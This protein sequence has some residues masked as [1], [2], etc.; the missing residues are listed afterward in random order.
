MARINLPPGCMG[1][2]DG[3]NKRFAER[4]NGGTH[5]NLD[6]TDPRDQVILQKMKNQDY[7]SAGLVD[8]GPEK[9]FIARRSRSR[10]RWCKACNFLGHSWMQRCSKC[11]GET[12]PEGDMD[13]SHTFEDAFPELRPMIGRHS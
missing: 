2:A 3:D 1:V 12:I 6:E 5:L 10:G 8:V 11:G 7:A 9:Q 4:G 13:L